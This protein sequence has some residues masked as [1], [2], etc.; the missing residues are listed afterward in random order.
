MTA[1][2]G[3]GLP[4]SRER[5][6]EHATKLALTSVF[7]GTVG[8]FAV[9]PRLRRS[10]ILR[11]GP[12]DLVM[13][14]L[15][16]YRV[17]HMVAYERIADPIRQPFAERA[18]DPENGGETIVPRGGGWRRALGEL[19]SCPICVGTWAATALVYGLH[20]LPRPTRAFITIM[21][22]TGVAEIL[23]TGIKALASLK[24]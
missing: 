10:S 5:T 13:L 15:T 24:R 14:G 18:P 8:A 11:M 21:S 2:G 6:E 16:T 23:N 22:A 17:G 19:F 7:L 1:S 3:G 9:I 12:M 4:E 20:F